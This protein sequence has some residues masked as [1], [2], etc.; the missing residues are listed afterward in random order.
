LPLVETWCRNPGIRYARQI[1][2]FCEDCGLTY[3]SISPG[4]SGSQLG[5]G[6]II[7]PMGRVALVPPLS[8]NEL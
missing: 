6:A 5:F 8:E 4:F 3:G 7:L 1:A 2:L